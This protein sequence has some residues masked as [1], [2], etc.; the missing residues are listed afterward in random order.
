LLLVTIKHLKVVMDCK[1]NLSHFGDF[2]VSLSPRFPAGN[3]SIR[4]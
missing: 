4:G 2:L 1:L 3:F